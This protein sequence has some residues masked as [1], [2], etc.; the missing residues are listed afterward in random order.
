MD[1]RLATFSRQ[2]QVSRLANPKAFD[3]SVNG[4]WT[5]GVFNGKILCKYL[6]FGRRGLIAQKIYSQFKNLDLVLGSGKNVKASFDKGIFYCLLGGKRCGLQ[7]QDFNAIAQLKKTNLEVSSLNSRF[8][9]GHFNGKGNVDFGFL[10]FHNDFELHLERVDLKRAAPLFKNFSGI[11]G[12]IDADIIYNSYPW[13]KSRGSFIIKDGSISGFGFLKWLGRSFEIKDLNS[14]DFKT[15]SSYFY[16]DSDDVEF[17]KFFVDSDKVK[18]RGNFNLKSGLISSKVSA[19]FSRQF[20]KDS[21]KLRPL[22][23]IL[24]KN[25][26]LIDFDFQLS[27]APDAVN[28]K[29]LNSDFK[30]RLYSKI[31]GFV[32]GSVEKDIENVLKPLLA[33]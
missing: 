24:G 27:G 22:V 30:E 33:Q 23:A 5:T 12:T 4:E 25:M 19:V 14:L 7:I 32:R 16:F 31:P 6:S 26:P 13:E 11:Q 20:L 1:M 17:K 28:F 15:A 3:L 21:K 2:A 29:W 18:L 8:Y 10:P 9:E